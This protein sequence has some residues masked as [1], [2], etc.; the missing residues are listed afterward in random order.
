LSQA[1][2]N[3][4]ANAISFA[5]PGTTV[6]VKLASIGAR[7]RVTIGDRGPGIPEAHLP[8]V[9]DRFFSYRPSEERREHLG[10]GLPIA[11]Q[12]IESYGGAITAR[13]RDGGGAL[14]V[15][16]LPAATGRTSSPTLSNPPGATAR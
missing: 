15:I 6:D 5:A 8:R 14:F 2:E 3:L 1:F 11:K 10:L 12:V 13:N 4:L 7:A 9:F 16:D